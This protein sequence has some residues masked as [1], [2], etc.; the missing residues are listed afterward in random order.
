VI[1]SAN[2]VNSK[3]LNIPEEKKI[4]VGNGKIIYFP[5]VEERK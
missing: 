3:K 4:I 2:D 1:I 5:R